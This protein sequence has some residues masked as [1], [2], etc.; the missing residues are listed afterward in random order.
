METVTRTTLNDI[1]LAIDR[2]DL[3]GKVAYPKHHLPND[4]P[5]LLRAAANS[6]GVFVNPALTEPFG[7]TLIEAAASGLPIV[8]TEDGGPCDIIK[9]LRNGRLINPLDT[10]ALADTLIEMLNDSQQW[11]EYSRSGIDRVGKLLF[12]AIAC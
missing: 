6:Q 5:V 10:A 11:R 12:L 4:V 7:L 3:Y 1:L 2:F 8:A 9:N